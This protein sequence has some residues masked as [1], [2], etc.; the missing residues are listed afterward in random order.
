[1]PTGF[2]AAPSSERVPIW[3]TPAQCVDLIPSKN[4][5]AARQWLIDH[6]IKRRNNGTVSR[7]DLERELARR[8]PKR[9]MHPKSLQNLSKRHEAADVDR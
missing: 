6:G 7:L 2:F 9:A 3:L 5:K 1:M 8:K 4:V